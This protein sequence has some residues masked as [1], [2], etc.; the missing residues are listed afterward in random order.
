MNTAHH[1]ELREILGTDDAAVT[2]ML[3]QHK[4][5]RNREVDHQAR[6]L[7]VGVAQRLQ[8]KNRVGS[9]AFAGAL[10]ASAAAIVVL[11]SLNPTHPQSG[12]TSRVPSSSA[13]PVA[14]STAP[15]VS[16]SASAVAQSQQPIRIHRAAQIA[17]VSDEVILEQEAENQL[18]NLLADA[19]TDEAA[20]TITNEDVDMILQENSNDNGL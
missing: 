8:K 3:V 18:V 19:V 5:R 9:T 1:D 12:E 13:L 4:E 20:W 11:I 10:A 7:S 6:N 16:A 17:T 2:A 14:A 15:V